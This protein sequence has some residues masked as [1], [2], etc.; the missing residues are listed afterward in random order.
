MGWDCW[1][2]WMAGGGREL[3]AEADLIV[4]VPLHYFRLV[5][6][7]FNQSGWLAAALSRSSGV[8]AVGRCAEA[9]AGDADPGRAVGET[10][11][12]AMFRVRSGCAAAARRW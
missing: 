5:R 1:R 11:G 4:P 6:R 9:D 8:Q 12:G 2:G 10:G 7:G 3:L